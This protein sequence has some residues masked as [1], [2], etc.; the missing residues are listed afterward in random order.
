MAQPVLSNNY[1]ASSW[2]FKSH[3]GGNSSLGAQ[4]ELGLGQVT[5]LDNSQFS[6]ELEL[7]LQG[8]RQCMDL[9]PGRAYVHSD[10]VI[11]WSL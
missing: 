2:G 9:D 10:D 3:E 7:A 6:G 8:S 4:H 5:Q 11:H 1:V